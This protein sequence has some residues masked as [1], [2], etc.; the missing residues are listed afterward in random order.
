MPGI[1]ACH[2]GQRSKLDPTGKRG[3]FVGYSETSKDYRIYV[4][5]FKKIEIRI[6]VTFDEDASF[7]KSKKNSSEEIQDKEPKAP[8]GLE[9]EAEEVVPEDHDEMERQRPEDPPKEVT[10]GKRRPAWPVSSC[11]KQRSIELQT[12]PSEKARNLKPIP[13]MWLYF[14]I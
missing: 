6:D 9:S 1:Y 7:C 8:R 13:V 5:G 14:K 11:R 12:K 4:P 2:P 10:L 3:I